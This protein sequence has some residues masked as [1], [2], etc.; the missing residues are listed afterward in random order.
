MLPPMRERRA[1]THVHFALLAP[2]GKDRSKALVI[3]VS[4]VPKGSST[5]ILSTENQIRVQTVREDTSRALRGPHIVMPAPLVRSI[6]IQQVHLRKKLHV[7]ILVAQGFKVLTVN[8]SDPSCTACP[9]GQY[10]PFP[11]SYQCYDCPPG[12][13]G[14]F[15]GSGYLS[16]CTACAVGQ[17]APM[18]GLSS[19]LLCPQGY[20]TENVTQMHPFEPVSSPSPLPYTKRFLF[21]EEIEIRGFKECKPC[22]VGQFAETQG[23]GFCTVC[24]R[25]NTTLSTGAASLGDC[26]ACPRGT[27]G[28]DDGKCVDCRLGRFS[29]SLGATLSCKAC[30][31][32]QF[33]N[34]TGQSSC[35]G[36]GEGYIPNPLDLGEATSFAEACIRAS[37]SSTPTPSRTVTSTPSHTPSRTSTESPSSSISPSVTASRTASISSTPTVTSTS[38]KTPSDTPTSSVTATRTPSNTPTSSRTRTATPTSSVTP[39]RTA[40]QTASNSATSTPSLTSSQTPSSTL[41]PSST[42]SSTASQTG[43]PSKTSTPSVTASRTQSGTP[44]ETASVSSTPSK[45]PSNSGTPSWT[46]SVTATASASSSASSSSVQR[47]GGPAKAEDEG[48]GGVVLI[49]VPIIAAIALLLC[50]IIAAFL[51]RRRRKQKE[52]ANSRSTIKSAKVEAVNPVA[53]MDTSGN[54]EEKVGESQKS[55]FNA[56]FGSKGKSKQKFDPEQRGNMPEGD[57]DSQHIKANLQGSKKTFAPVSSRI[58]QTDHEDEEED[59]SSGAALGTGSTVRRESSVQF[60]IENKMGTHRL[61]RNQNQQEGGDND[62]RERSNSRAGR[63]RKLMGF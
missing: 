1:R 19:C 30:Q 8:S 36:C 32:G 4:I 59:T 9:E 17:Y 53:G 46:S 14:I 45:T 25:G 34:T 55:G 13:E 12:Q 2:T 58:L 23:L 60:E 7:V 61:A 56:F 21:N 51:V 26:I 33:Q 20:S 39:S 5:T 41:T 3:C 18:S 48:P 24:P 44:S 40:S 62:D 11:K 15:P 6:M 22:P 63:I 42:G 16:N 54:D 31:A 10:Q 27:F 47:G 38:T 50:L 49:G 52:A 37:P 28:N 35:F 29:A 43:T 57:S